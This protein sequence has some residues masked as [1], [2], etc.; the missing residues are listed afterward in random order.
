MPS[1]LNNNKAK[2]NVFLSLICRLRRGKKKKGEGDGI[3][4]PLDF[5]LRFRRG[6]GGGSL[7]SVT[8]LKRSLFCVAQKRGGETYGKHLAV[9]KQILKLSFP[10]MTCGCNIIVSV[11]TDS[12]G[13]VAVK[14][15][16]S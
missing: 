15:G 6:E 16:G 11:R 8:K 14:G 3:D 12:S 10:Y 7:C 2:K 4:F 5:S 9:E 13:Y 1:P